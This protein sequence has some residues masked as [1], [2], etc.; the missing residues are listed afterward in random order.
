[1]RPMLGAK[2]GADMQGDV[3]VKS[4]RRKLK[5]KKTTEATAEQLT[6]AKFLSTFQEKVDDTKLDEDC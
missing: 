1:M 3:R 2:A 5:S 6:H 4:K